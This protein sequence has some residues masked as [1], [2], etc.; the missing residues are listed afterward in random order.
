MHNKI[1][2]MNELKKI[3]SVLKKIDDSSLNLNLLVIDSTIGQ[4]ALK[5]VESFKS[6]VDINGIIVTKLDG[7]SKAGIIV[8]ITQKIYD[9]NLLRRYWRGDRRF[10]LIFCRRFCKCTTY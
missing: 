9:T 2:L 6:I 10:E 7:T 8:P 4:T 1:D 3:I 5:Q